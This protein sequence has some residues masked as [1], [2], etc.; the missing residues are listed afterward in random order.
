MH[1]C[2]S[3]TVKAA[4]DHDAWNTVKT[5]YSFA[6]SQEK[7][8][9]N[10]AFHDTYWV[11]RCDSGWLL[12]VG[13]RRHERKLDIAHKYGSWPTFSGMRI[14]LPKCKRTGAVHLPLFCLDEYA[15]SG[16]S[17][18]ARTIA[19]RSRCEWGMRNNSANKAHLVVSICWQPR[20]RSVPPTFFLHLLSRLNT[21][22]GS[23]YQTK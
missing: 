7:S 19:W 16:A 18:A 15:T 21:Y 9:K 1:F 14:A 20:Q 10:P 5:H 12:R 17:T 6:I 2:Y 22:K 13:E 11:W 8:H 4:K 23:N 3:R